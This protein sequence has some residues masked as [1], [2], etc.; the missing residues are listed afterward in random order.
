MGDLTLAEIESALEKQLQPIHDDIAEI[1]LTM[2]GPEGRTGVAADVTEAHGLAKKHEVMLRGR[3]G[4][5][6]IVKKINYL[7]GVALSGAA[8]LFWKAVDFF[9]SNPPPPPPHH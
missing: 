4:T 9:S 6:G 8:G 5:S 3:D 7:W 1:K 2:F